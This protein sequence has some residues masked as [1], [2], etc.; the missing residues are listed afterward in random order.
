MRSYLFLAVLVTLGASAA[1]VAQEPRDIVEKAIKAHGGTAA[2][3][4]LK[5]MRE[6]M[7]GKFH[8]GGKSFDFTSDTLIQLPNRFRTSLQADVSG[9]KLDLV[10]ILGGDEGWLLDD[11]RVT[12][13]EE[14]ML[15]NW[16]E[17]IHAVNASSFVPVLGDKGFELVALPEIKI[18]N[19]PAVGVRVVRKERRDVKLYFDKE[20]SLLVKRE[21]QAWEGGKEGTRE[22][23]YSD[24][25]DVQGVKR[26]MKVVI[27]Q[28]GQKYMDATVTS[29]E[30][31]D[32]IDPREFAK[33]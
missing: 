28:H 11:G 9:R 30:F 8:Q 27:V 22:E 6:K 10:Q 33:P 24:Y 17:L 20:T 26:P 32:R 15:E 31:L 4:K 5:A 12:P 18:E 3:S 2:L 1:G 29:V 19:K 21:F 25:K 7:R 14:K 13:V 16:K 23:F